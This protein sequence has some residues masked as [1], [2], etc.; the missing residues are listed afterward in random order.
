M[1]SSSLAHAVERFADVTQ[2][3]PDRD[4]DREWAWGAYDAEG[5]RFAFFRTYEDLR[6]LAART[7]AERLAH[8]PAMSTAQRILAQ[9]HAAYRDLQAALLGIGPDEADRAPAAEEW[10][11][12]QIVAHI[13]GAE[14]GFFAVAKYALDR[15]RGGD[16]RPAKIPDEA[17]EPLFG[18]DMALIDA[19]LDGP[20]AGMRSYHEAFHERIVR[21]FAGIGEEELALPSIYWEGYELSLRFRLHR[22]DSHLRQHTVQIDKTRESIG[23]SPN[24]AQRL[25][26]LIYA[27]LAEAEGATIGAPEINTELWQGTAETI[28]TRTDE[29]AA[30]VT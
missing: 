29:I 8:G 28:A 5:V 10:P 17:W 23:R 30:I 24:E 26:R 18:E 22:F 12:R 7:A 2:G 9:V 3:L 1:F 13:V 27:A 19:T 21:E 14:L 16:W 6:E 15:H 25:L 20:L 4:L 11:L